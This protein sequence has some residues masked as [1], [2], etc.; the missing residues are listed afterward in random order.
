MCVEE[1]HSLTVLHMVGHL[2]VHHITN[3]FEDRSCHSKQMHTS[4]EVTKLGH[5]ES[6]LTDPVVCHP[7]IEGGGG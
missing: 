2:L 3:Y 1:T 6:Y 4:I 7:C 5:Y